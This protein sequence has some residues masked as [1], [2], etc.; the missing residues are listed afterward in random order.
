MRKE[1]RMGKCFNPL[2][3]SEKQLMCPGSLLSERKENCRME[4]RVKSSSAHTNHLSSLPL[5]QPY[6]MVPHQKKNEF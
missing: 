5:L 6:V 1:Q 4:L 2:N 3:C